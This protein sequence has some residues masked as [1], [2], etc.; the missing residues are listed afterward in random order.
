ML[1]IT[2]DSLFGEAVA[3]GRVETLVSLIAKIP[4]FRASYSTE[5]VFLALRLAVARGDIEHHNIVF[6]YKCQ[7]IRISKYGFIE[8]WPKGFCDTTDDTINEILKIAIIP[9]LKK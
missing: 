2:Y 9:Y 6:V 1:R 7:E 5:N 8:D 3:D 4:D